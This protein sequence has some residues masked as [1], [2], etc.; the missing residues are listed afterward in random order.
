MAGIMMCEG[1]TCSLKYWCRRYTEEANPR[2][3]MYFIED[4]RH[5]SD[6]PLVISGDKLADE[7][8]FYLSKDGEAQCQE[9]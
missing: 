7:C 6:D 1:Y 2:G 3:Q 9:E 8:D 4:P 5:K